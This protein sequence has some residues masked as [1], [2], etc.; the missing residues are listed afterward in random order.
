MCTPYWGP[1]PPSHPAPL[2]PLSAAWPPQEW[3]PLHSTPPALTLTDLPHCPAGCNKATQL[4]CS[5]LCNGK[6]PGA[7]VL[8][9]PPLSCF[10]P[11]LSSYLA[12][13]ED[14][15]YFGLFFFSLFFFFFS[16]FLKQ[17]CGLRGSLTSLRFIC[18]VSFSS[19]LSFCLFFYPGKLLV[20]GFISFLVCFGSEWSGLL[21]RVHSLH[22]LHHRHHHHTHVHWSIMLCSLRAW[23][24]EPLAVCPPMAF[25]LN[26]WSALWLWPWPCS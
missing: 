2:H 15:I 13:D 11:P 25:T 9:S 1:R 19:S 18:N 23:S 21:S 7:G 26:S 17:L 14:N 20:H 3:A 12:E 6:C 5:P 22:L 16:F 8:L 24:F 10:P 4:Q